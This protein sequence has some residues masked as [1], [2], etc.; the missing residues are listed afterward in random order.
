M[1]GGDA[2]SD[3]DRTTHTD[4]EDPNYPSDETSGFSGI[5]PGDQEPREPQ[6][7]PAADAETTLERAIA[8]I[9]D[10]AERHSAREAL[11][12]M[13]QQLDDYA[14]LEQ[15]ML[16]LDQIRDLLAGTTYV[17]DHPDRDT[18]GDVEDLWDSH[19]AALE[20][21]AEAERQ[22]AEATKNSG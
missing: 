21:W 7:L 16:Q 20:A 9:D 5:T 19:M 4:W 18:A 1:D 22:A 14:G 17:E 3:E 2:V 12:E 13:R 11:E 15:E 6:E 8:Q 10:P